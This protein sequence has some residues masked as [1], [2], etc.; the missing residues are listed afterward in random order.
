M[1]GT[2]LSPELIKELRTAAK[3]MKKKE[4]AILFRAGDRGTGAFVVRRGQIKLTLEG[5]A[6][7]Y[8]SRTLGPG[9]IA[10]LPATV[11]GEPYSLT[12]EAIQDCELD[13]IPR[14]ELLALIQRN[15]KAALQILQILSEEIYNM[16]NTAQL[17]AQTTVT[18]H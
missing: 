13:F 15:T 2:K 4:G 10:G 3:P 7:L 6:A 8:P 11:S 1:P 18:V 12:A 14:E 9:A 5:G 16:R 17:A